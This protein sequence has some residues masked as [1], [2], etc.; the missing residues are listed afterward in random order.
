[1]S[2]IP[3]ANGS[4]ESFFSAMRQNPKKPTPEKATPD[5]IPPDRLDLPEGE[6]KE[7][8]QKS[9]YSLRSRESHKRKFEEYQ[10][11]KYYLY[12]DTKPMKKKKKI[13]KGEKRTP[14]QVIYIQISGPECLFE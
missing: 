5:K 7:G 10:H 8:T 3:N 14:V 11:N 1:M 13:T 4:L 6:I 2:T 9:G 12:D